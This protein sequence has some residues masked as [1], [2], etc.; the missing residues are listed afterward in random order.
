M[1]ALRGAVSTAL[2][3]FARVS[4][5]EEDRPFALSYEASQGCPSASDVQARIHAY[6]AHARPA[7]GDEPHYDVS[8]V[9]ARSESGFLASLQVHGPDGTETSRAVPAPT[10]A[11]VIDA[12]SLIVAITIDPEA[13]ALES[14]RQDAAA[15]KEQEGAQ[16]SVP[17]TAP[18]ATRV[19]TQKEPEKPEVR[20]RPQP[21]ALPEDDERAVHFSVDAGLGVVLFAIAPDPAIDFLVGGAFDIETA[22]TFAPRL[23]LS[24][25]GSKSFSVNTPSGRAQFERWAGRFNACPFRWGSR[26][27]GVRPCALFE[28]GYYAAGGYEPNGGGDLFPFLWGA[29][30]AALRGEL[31]SSS[32]WAAH[33]DLGVLFPLIAGE[34]F[35]FDPGHQNVHEIPPV[36]LFLDL[37]AEFQIL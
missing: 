1:H 25:H 20:R 9:V 33:A 4:A 21:K 34:S 37:A 23:E 7:V 29:P 27:A 17:E 19:E 11:E 14:A 18:A 24:L 31:R 6:T 15:K 2:L 28:I 16:K 35:Y 13:A 30:G 10:C 32:R 36:G 3:T 22:R 12:V 5:A 26:G 8:V